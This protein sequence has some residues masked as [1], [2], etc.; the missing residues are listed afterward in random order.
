MYGWCLKRGGGQEAGVRTSLSMSLSDPAA[1]RRRTH[2]GRPLREATIRAESPQRFTDAGSAPDSSRMRTHASLPLS[3]AQWSG[4]QPH[5]WEGAT[6]GRQRR[7]ARVLV[8][9]KTGGERATPLQSRTLFLTVA[10]APAA[11]STRTLSTCPLRQARWMGCSP[12][13]GA[14]REKGSEETCLWKRHDARAERRTRQPARESDTVAG[15]ASSPHLYSPWE[16][17]APG[18]D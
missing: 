12:S 11:V 16:P 1:R 10:E 5:W 6:G 3:A 9:K 13:C 14:Q 18:E 7:Q 8:E 4:D 2:S 17:S 15:R